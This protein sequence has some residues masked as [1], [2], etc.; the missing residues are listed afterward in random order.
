MS[1]PIGPSSCCGCA[2]NSCKATMKLLIQNAEVVTPRERFLTD[3]FLEGGQ[4]AMTGSALASRTNPDRVID[5]YGYLVFPG[6]IDPHVHMHLPTSSGFSSDDFNS[7]SK[8]ALLGGTTTLVDFVTPRRGQ[9]LTQALAERRAEAAEAL[10]DH[11]LHVSPVEWRESLPME[12]EACIMAGAVSFKVYMAYKDAIGVGDEV[13]EKVLK[14]VGRAGGMVTL[15]AELGDE[16]DRL[17][18]AL[19]EKGQRGP[20]AHPLSRP[21]HTESQAVARAIDLAG[22][23][24]CP[25]YI[26]H[27]SAKASVE[28]IRNAR[29]KGQAVF[30]EACPHHLL[31]DESRYG[32]PFHEAAPFVMSPPLRG[33]SDRE[34]L[35]EALA[36]G[37]IQ[38]VGTDHCPFM[39]AQKEQGLDDFRKIANGA[40]SVE[41]RLSLLYTYGV[42]EGRISIN[43]FVEL[44]SAEPAALFGMAPRKGSLQPGAD[45]DLVIWNPLYEGTVS[46]ATHQQR[47]DHNIFEGFHVKGRPEYVIARGEVA[48]ENGRLNPLARGKYLH[49]TLRK[50]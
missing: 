1:L 19:F 48:V 12:I 50:P 38:V 22:R 21:P 42:L 10:T 32:G 8:A 2:Q 46:A 7:G 20:S 4:I 47:C 15:H 28:A 5:A 27:V 25:L 23:S 29:A 26:V 34:A 6:G 40:G 39:M 49:R 14:A 18:D 24:G 43:R 30:A 33:E 16:I 11:G 13:L 35:W 3:L 17:R 45:A 37:T 44:V 36:D 31:L 9:A 41:H